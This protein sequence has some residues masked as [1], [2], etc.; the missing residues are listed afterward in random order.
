MKVLVALAGLILLIAAGAL[1]AETPPAGAS[2]SETAPAVPG[3]VYRALILSGVA[4]DGK[5]DAAFRETA[6]RLVATLTGPYGYPSDQVTLL[7]DDEN[8]VG[9]G[10]DALPT[11]ATIEAT[12]AR[13]RAATK[14]EDQLLVVVIGHAALTSGGASLHLPGPDLSAEDFG[15]L[16]ESFPGRLVVIV[17][18]PVSGYFMGPLR[19]PDRVVITAT[20]QGREINETRFGRVFAELLETSANAGERPA[21]DELYAR[22][23]TQVESEFKAAGLIPTE[24]AMLDDNG[25]GVGTR[26]LTETSDDGALARATY[27]GPRVTAAAKPEAEPEVVEA[28]AKWAALKPP[29]VVLLEDIEYAVNSDLTYRIRERHR[30]K[31]LNK[32]GHRFSEVIIFYNTLSETL[33]IEEAKTIK[34]DGEVVP[35]DENQIQDVK[36]TTSLFYTESRYKRFSMPSVEDGCVLD[37]TFVKTGRNVH[38]SREFWKTFDVEMDVPQELVRVTLTVPLA[39][40][41]AHKLRPEAPAFGVEVSKSEDKYSRTLV[42]TMRDIPPLSAEPYA[43]SSAA[44]GTRLIFTSIPSWDTVWD[45]YRRLTDGA[46][47]PT[48]AIEQAVAQTIEG[49]ETDLDKARAIYNYVCSKIRY[50]G[51]ELGPYGYQPHSAESI[52][53]NRYGDCKDKAALLL[54]MLDVAGIHGSMVLLSTDVM[55]PVD[56]EMPTLDQ[57]NHA[58]ATVEIGG[59]RYWLDTTGGETAFG[60]IPLSDQGRMGFV[61]GEKAG[62]FI[63]IPVQPAEANAMKSV[64][65]AAIGLDGALR[66]DERIE[67]TGAFAAMFRHK[68]RYLDAADQR[69]QLA[70]ALGALSA[71]ATLDDYSIAG[72][73]DLADTL[74]YTRTVTAPDYAAIADDLMVLTAPLQDV[75]LLSVTALATRT[76][77]LRVGQTMRREAQLT[78]ALPKGYGVRNLP[79][80]VALTTEIGSYTE[81]YSVNQDGAIVCRKTFELRVPEVTPEQYPAFRDFVRRVA[82][83]QRR[84]IVLIAQPSPDGPD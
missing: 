35:L 15:K 77:P 45:W 34:A 13:L 38:L 65:T 68:Y 51:L 29:A 40:R 14:P 82:R 70:E 12:V 83:E 17:A 78:L 23:V 37:Y 3:G 69:R 10:V 50:V 57:F 81:T 75:G 73:D 79:K 36:S 18:T 71:G 52:W 32:G 28:G 22:T 76:Q 74:V 7:F 47:V 25:D 11:R 58:I 41:V 5:H 62:E 80:P 67:C 26:A 43:P 33:K 2:P 27:V 6:R 55:A 30:V 19:G 31:V 84:I 66:L 21:L 72:M 16:F 64:G 24:H 20:K 46:R 49:A 8:E 53:A 60:D 61:V 4:G 63:R 39:K 54:T 56:T 1:A 48:E 9:Q 44:L 42:F 59:T